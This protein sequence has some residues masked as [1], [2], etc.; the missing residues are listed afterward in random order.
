MCVAAGY[1]D[2]DGGGPQLPNASA[3]SDRLHGDAEEFARSFASGAQEWAR[4]R[5]EQGSAALSSLTRGGSAPLLRDGWTNTSAWT[6]ERSIC[7]ACNQSVRVIGT[8]FGCT[9]TCRQKCP[10]VM[11]AAGCTGEEANPAC[12]KCKATCSLLG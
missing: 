2:G 10:E 8:G 7:L 4:E 5:T 1:G 3:L 11:R 9:S 12:F 6:A